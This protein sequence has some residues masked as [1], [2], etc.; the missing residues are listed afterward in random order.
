[1]FFLAVDI[2]VERLLLQVPGSQAIWACRYYYH[3]GK[4]PCDAKSDEGLVLILFHSK[5]ASTGVWL[6]STGQITTWCD[7]Q[8]SLPFSAVFLA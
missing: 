4:R 6:A 8:V 5:E 1:M 7:S 2:E 3:R